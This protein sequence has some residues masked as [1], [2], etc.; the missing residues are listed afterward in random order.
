MF[1]SLIF[2]YPSLVIGDGGYR[3]SVNYDSSAPW[4][5]A[6]N[7]FAGQIMVTALVC[8]VIA[9]VIGVVLFLFG[10]FS[11]SGASQTVGLTIVLWVAGGAAIIGGISALIYWGSGLGLFG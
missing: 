1:D 8:L 2:R 5:S 6:L 3:P 11:K 9:G 7:K 10:K 4:M